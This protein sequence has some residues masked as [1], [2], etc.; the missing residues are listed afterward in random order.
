MFVAGNTIISAINVSKKQVL[1]NRIPVINYAVESR[2][3]SLKVFNEYKKLSNEIDESYKVALKLTS[4]DMNIKLINNII[5]IFVDKNVKVLIDAENNKYNN[6]YNKITQSLL[7]KYNKNDINIYKT[8]Q[9]YR[10]DSLSTLMYDMNFCNKNNLFLGTKIV[11]GAY[12]NNENKIGHLFINKSDTDRS[13]NNA[14]ISLYEYEGYSGNILATHNTESI[15]LGILLNER[16]ENIFSFAHLLDMKTKKYN[17]ITKEGKN[18][19]VYIPYGPYNEMIPY[20]GRRLYEN[21]D[22]FKYLL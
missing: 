10:K 11:R 1:K 18:V 3:D 22:T 13:Y 8:Y 9:M 12:W 20:L 2:S 16:K 7:N 17:Q 21:L 15:N 5:D 19:H 6:E 14:I 4:F